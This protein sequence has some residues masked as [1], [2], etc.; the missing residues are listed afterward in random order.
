[1]DRLQP[2][3][4][5]EDIP[6]GRMSWGPAKTQRSTDDYGTAIRHPT[7]RTLSTAGPSGLGLRR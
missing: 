6:P 7:T 4:L 1:M 3:A 5:W 2:V